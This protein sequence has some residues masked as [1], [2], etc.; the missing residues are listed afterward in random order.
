MGG[1][2]ETAFIFCSV[3]MMVSS[4]RQGGRFATPIAPRPAPACDSPWGNQDTRVRLSLANADKHHDSLPNDV[5][6]L[7]QLLL[8]RNVEPA[9]ARAEAS[10]ARAEAPD[11]RAEISNAEALIAYRPPLQTLIVAA[12]LIQI[13]ARQMV[14]I[15]G[16]TPARLCNHARRSC[17]WQASAPCTPH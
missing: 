4:N 1:L 8:E 15:Y 7:Q 12:V 17:R 13:V 2:G 3:V 14:H 10:S 16:A 6:T 11:A 9:Q 5:A